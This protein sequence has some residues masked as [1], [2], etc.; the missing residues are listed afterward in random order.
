[1]AGSILPLACNSDKIL[2]N[3][4]GDPK[5]GGDVGER[6]TLNFLIFQVLWNVFL[7]RIRPLKCDLSESSN[8]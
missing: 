1:M 4:K 7:K 2:S 3:Q 8:L 6:V 5:K